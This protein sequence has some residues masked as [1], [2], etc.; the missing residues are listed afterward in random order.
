MNLLIVNDEELTAETMKSDMDWKRYGIDRAF[1]AYDADQARGVIKKETVDILLCDIE[2]PGDNG[3]ELLRWVRREELPIECIF[4]TCHPSFEYAREAIS[5]NCQ[6]YILIPAQYEDIGR[7]IKKVVDRILASRESEELAEYGRHVVEE[8]IQKAAG[9][10]GGKKSSK[11][12]VKDIE[13]YICR[14]LGDEEL[15]V[16]ALGNVFYMHPVHVNR[17]FKKELNTSVSQYIMEERMKLAAQLLKS[18]KLSMAAVSEQ[19]GYKGYSNFNNAFKKYYG[20]TPSEYL[21]R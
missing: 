15:S 21:R 10:H 1:T 16:N 14:N 8:K 4:L 17:L 12:L 19:V 6:D 3:I 11:E 13:A 5:L 9:A 20:C 7:G 18:G 2:M